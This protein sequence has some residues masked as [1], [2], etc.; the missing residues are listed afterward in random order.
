VTV[1]EVLRKL[2]DVRP[3]GQHRWMGRCPVPAH[4]DRDASLSVALGRGGVL[5]HCFGGCSAD[6][7]VQALGLDWPSLFGC[8]GGVES[9]ARRELTE[10]DRA[11]RHRAYCRLGAMLPLEEADRQALLARG[12]S[13]AA[14]HFE[15]Y[16]T[17]DPVA[18][19]NAAKRLLREFGE[20]L[21]TVP[22][23][24]KKGPGAALAVSEGLLVPQRDGDGRITAC[25][26][27][28]GREGRKYVCFSS[29][30]A[31]SGSVPHVPLGAWADCEGVVRI[32]EGPLKANVASHLDP[33]VPTVAIPGVSA[34]RCVLPALWSGVHTVRLA[35]D[36]D[37]QSK[38]TVKRAMR[39]L[40]EALEGAG[41]KVELEVWPE[42]EA[43]GI[44]DL[45]RAG[46]RPVIH[47]EATKQ[48]VT[49][50][51]EEL[52]PDD[53]RTVV[54]W[55]HEIPEGETKW[56]WELEIPEGELTIMDGDPGLGKSTLDC[57]I[58]ARVTRGEPFPGEGKGLRRPPAPVVWISAEDDASKTTKPRLR[59]AG[60]DLTK[61]A[62]WDGVRG[63][64]S[65]SSADLVSLPQFPQDMERLEWMVRKHG[66]RLVVIDPLF[67]H[68]DAKYDSHK[69]Q[70]IRQVLNR[71]AD[72]AHQAGVAVLCVRHLNKKEGSAGIYR[73]S[74]SIGVIGA[75]R[76]GKVFCPCPKRPETHRYLL[77]SKSNL[78]PH[79]K[80]WRI[81]LESDPRKKA[82]PSW[83]VFEGQEEADLQDLLDRKGGNGAAKER[84]AASQFLFRELARGPVAAKKLLEM[85]GKIGI[86][87]WVLRRAKQYNLVPHFKKGEVTYWGHPVNEKVL[88]DAD[89]KAT[90]GAAPAQ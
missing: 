14:V 25:Q 56:L 65:K 48:T 37:W 19:Q 11:L 61:V 52:H 2:D 46:K 76:M 67:A 17:L 77:T 22:G 82:G 32:T 62:F 29:S 55:G 47:R 88:T 85:A 75:A 3:K 7:V 6:A 21:F 72:L 79:P 44:D 31:S 36:A 78:G 68:I 64:G 60:A 9:A 5:F 26:V 70:H 84:G 59:A 45:L 10:E 57:F 49:P 40:W 69:D 80:P 20:P 34:W 33:E 74:G 43:K 73:G 15:M 54:R 38:G 30:E 63:D 27:R 53:G 24:L 39:D 51:W 71:M 89:Q 83:V 81:R 35:F 42:R 50:S 41:L 66:V 16:R 8:G 23:F 90:G 18:C 28:T 4:G 1:E 87:E 86:T 12:L 13:P 58:A